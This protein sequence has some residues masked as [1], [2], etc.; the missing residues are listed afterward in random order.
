MNLPNKNFN[1]LSKFLKNDIQQFKL[2]LN[3]FSLFENRIID[4]I[5]FH[6]N[7]Y[8]FVDVG[9]K[10]TIKLSSDVYLKYHTLLKFIRLETLFND[11]LIDFS[12]TK[13]SITRRLNWSIIKKAFNIRC[14]LPGKVLN[15]I[16]NGF[17]IGILGFVGFMPK[18]YAIDNS[19]SLKSIF[20]INSIDIFKKTFT[21]SQKQID[22]ITFR[23]LFKL[24]S[25]ISYI[26]KN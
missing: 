24:S 7:N 16:K 8:I 3:C 9:F 13:N 22:K 23:V 25:Q 2:Y 19:S 21:V 6:L 11:S 15:P 10:Y 20:I 14:I 12:N 1:H 5:K 26:S 17:S 4:S 18:K